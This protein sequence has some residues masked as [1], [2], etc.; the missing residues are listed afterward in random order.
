M[1]GD[2]EGEE[3][4]NLSPGRRRDLRNPAMLPECGRGDEGDVKSSNPWSSSCLLSSL[5]SE[6]TDPELRRF[7]SGISIII[8]HV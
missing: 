1:A 7:E 3:P 6:F 4:A 2:P 8:I 5:R